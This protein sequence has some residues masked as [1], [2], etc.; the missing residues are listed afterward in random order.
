AQ[1][2]GSGV[3][4]RLAVASPRPA[5]PL[6]ARRNT[7]PVGAPVRSGR[8]SGRHAERHA[9]RADMDMT[10]DD[11]FRSAQRKGR[12]ASICA[13]SFSSMEAMVT[14]ASTPPDSGTPSSNRRTGRRPATRSHSARM[15]GAN[16]SVRP[17]P[18]QEHHHLDAPRI[19][20]TGAS[21]SN[22][23][24]SSPAGVRRRPA[25]GRRASSMHH[26][27]TGTV[28]RDHH[29]HRK[30]TAF[31]DVPDLGHARGPDEDEDSYRLRSFSATSKGEWRPTA[32]DHGGTGVL[33]V[34]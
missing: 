4:F 25:G 26:A 21:G 6:V 23:P 12:S 8:G 32:S 29:Q 2:S 13:P 16:K 1:P 33:P 14:A 28:H 9:Q 3:V 7:S 17:R 20:V 10:A 24:E 34:Q 27:H 5:P 15:S 30:S 31:L 19:G 11:M 22:T 18:A